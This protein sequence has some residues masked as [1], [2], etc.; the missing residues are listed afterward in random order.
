MPCTDVNQNTVAS[1]SSA[2]MIAFSV[3]ERALAPAS[4]SASSARYKRPGA[5]AAMSRK[6]SPSGVRSALP[7]IATSGTNSRAGKGGK[8]TNHRSLYSAKSLSCV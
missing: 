6:N 8:L 4:R 5:A 2:A 1:G 7:E 3:H